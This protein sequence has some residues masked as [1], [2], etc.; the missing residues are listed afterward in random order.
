MKIIQEQRMADCTSHYYVPAPDF[1]F[2]DPEER[3]DHLMALASET[4]VD[5]SQSYND[6]LL[7]RERYEYLEAKV[8]SAGA[9]RYDKDRVQSSNTYDLGDQVLDV[10]E[11]E[12]NADYASFLFCIY[13]IG[14]KQAM[15]HAGFDNAQQQVWILRYIKGQ[16][17]GQ[18]ADK[19]KMT[20]SHVQYLLS[21]RAETDFCNGLQ[22]LRESG[23]QY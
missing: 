17:L 19:L 18:I 10:M 23:D 12:E 3:V 2:I 13:F 15:V 22:L 20:R 7:K 11:A 1:K 8:S 5:A 16:S 4:K 21:T 9:I 6:M 14:F